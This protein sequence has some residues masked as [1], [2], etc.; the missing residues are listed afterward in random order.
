MRNITCLYHTEFKDNQI[1]AK[2]H[3]DIQRTSKYDSDAK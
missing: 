1:K 3:S 2:E